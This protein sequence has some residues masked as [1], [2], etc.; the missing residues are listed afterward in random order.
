MHFAISVANE[1]ADKRL[2][3]IDVVRAVNL[4]VPLATDAG[5]NLRA[6]GSWKISA[7]I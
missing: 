5:W 7:A 6:K 3:K 1:I 2:N 4:Q